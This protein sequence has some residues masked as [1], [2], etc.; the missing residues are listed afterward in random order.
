MEPMMPP[1]APPA[2]GVVASGS[3]EQPEEV[4][5]KGLKCAFCMDTFGD[6][7][8]ES[9]VCGHTFHSS[10]LADYIEPTGKSKTNACPFK[11]HAHAAVSFGEEEVIE[12]DNDNDAGD[13]AAAFASST[14]RASDA[15]AALAEGAHNEAVELFN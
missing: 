10:C 13:G 6:K 8:V 5:S 15:D 11:C 9:L 1:D 3:I 2:Q 7:E 4:E 12:L 14:A